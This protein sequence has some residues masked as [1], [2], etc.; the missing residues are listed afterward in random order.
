M[1]NNSSY[2]QLILSSSSPARRML[3]ARLPIPFTST[4]PDVDETPLPDEDVKSM[5]LRL[6][7][8]KAR[9]SATIYQGSLIIGCDQ[10]GTLDNTILCKPLTH[11]NAIKQ[12]RLVSGKVV[13]FYTAICLLDTRTNHIQSTIEIYDVYFRELSNA[14]IENYLLKENPYQCAGSF[15]A[16]GLGIALIEKFHGDDY[17]ALIGLPLI[18]LVQM[19]EKVGVNPLGS[20]NY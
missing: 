17:T 3:L 18:K 10:V 2:P 12:L 11:E 5:V 7:E 19:L 8:A 6:A 16:E 1:Q 20:T 15:R 9:K 14:L 13:R 4:S